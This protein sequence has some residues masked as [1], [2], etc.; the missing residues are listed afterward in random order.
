MLT[1]AASTSRPRL[2]KSKNK[3]A[4]EPS[5][6]LSVLDEH[7]LLDGFKIVIDLEKSRGSY[8]YDAATGR[9]L[10]DLYGFFGSMPVGFNHP[11]FDEPDVKA[12][13]V[14][15]G[16]GEG[17]E[18]GCLLG[19]LRQVRRNLRARCRFAAARSLFLHRRRRARG[20]KHAQG[21]DGLEGAQKHGRRSRRARHRDFAFPSRVSRSQRLHHEPDQHRSAQN[22]FVRQVRLAARFLSVHRFFVAGIGTRS[23]M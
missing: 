9:R 8:L 14:A 2:S 16:E 15:R 1:E 22:G 18:L 17:R 19:S 4:I 3:K 7:I 5:R 21:R 20:R 23:R 6:V 13:S 12:R 10:I 11:Y